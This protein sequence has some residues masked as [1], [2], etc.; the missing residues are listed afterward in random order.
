[1]GAGEIVVSSSEEEAKP[2]RNGKKHKKCKKEMKN[3]KD[4]DFQKPKEK[5]EEARASQE[6]SPPNPTNMPVSRAV[7][8][9]GSGNPPPSVKST[10]YTEDIHEDGHTAIWGSL[11]QKTSDPSMPG[12]GQ[13]GY[14][15]CRSFS[16]HEPCPFALNLPAVSTKKQTSQS[17]VKRT[18][19]T[20]R[21]QW[22]AS[23]LRDKMERGAMDDDAL[24]VR[25][26]RRLQEFRA[27]FVDSEREDLRQAAQRIQDSEFGAVV[28]LPKNLGNSGVPLRL[29]TRREDVS[30]EWAGTGQPLIGSGEG[31][32][33]GEW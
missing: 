10:L 18:C 27:L 32:S 3:K 23:L 31:D 11:W 5:R 29:F 30:W 17:L 24:C 12:M 2:E 8:H 26:R 28:E 4:K 20:G 9:Y 22:E 25:K 21:E 33:T 6:V 7:M 13:W 15:C 16:R 14:A 19:E 1:M